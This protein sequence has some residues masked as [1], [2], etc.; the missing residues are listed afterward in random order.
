MSGGQVILELR[1]I[2][3]SGVWKEVHQGYLAAKPMPNTQVAMAQG[4]QR[5]QRVA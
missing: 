4:A 3:F 5:E 2:G 1:V